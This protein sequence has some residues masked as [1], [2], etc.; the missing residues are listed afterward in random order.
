LKIACLNGSPN[1]K[2]NTADMIRIFSEEAEKSGASVETINLNKLN[3]KGCQACMMCKGKIDHC[4][5]K[6]D[7]FDVLNTVKNADVLVLGSPIYFGEVTSQMKGFIDRTF[8]YLTPG[9]HESEKPSRLEPGKTLVMILPQGAEDPA[10]F[11]DV[12]PRYSMFLKWMGYT[13]SHSLRGCGLGSDGDLEKHPEMIAEI[14][15]TVKTIL[16]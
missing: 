11:D 12:F 9:F 4:V 5:L 1:I 3:Y 15:N 10:S 13:T 16:G 7:L 2:G 8:S 6:D 14:R